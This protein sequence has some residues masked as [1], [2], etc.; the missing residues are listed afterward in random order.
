MSD[1]TCSSCTVHSQVEDIVQVAYDKRTGDLISRDGVKRQ[2]LV[3]R[4][5]NGLEDSWGVRYDV[6]LVDRFDPKVFDGTPEQALEEG[7]VQNE[8]GWVCPD[9]S[10]LDAE[11]DGVEHGSTLNPWEA[12][13]PSK[14]AEKE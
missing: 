1:V 7:W 12:M 8:F 6:G 13:L 11:E 9:C 4:V 3:S 5:L 2:D 10:A 14:K